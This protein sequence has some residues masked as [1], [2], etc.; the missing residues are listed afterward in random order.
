[1]IALYLIYIQ[2][3]ALRFDLVITD[4]L[5]IDLSLLDPIKCFQQTTYNQPKSIW[6][7]VTN[8]FKIVSN[9]NL[10]GDPHFCSSFEHQIK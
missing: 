3:G 1:M 6:D 8:L 2:K 5:P 9:A 4:S 7:K 10:S